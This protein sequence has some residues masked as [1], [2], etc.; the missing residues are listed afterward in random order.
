MHSPAIAKEDLLL[1][2]IQNDMTISSERAQDMYQASLE[3]IS[4]NGK[5]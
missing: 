4:S 3:L 1:N 5:K 2:Q